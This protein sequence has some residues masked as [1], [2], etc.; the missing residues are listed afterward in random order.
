MSWIFAIGLAVICFAVIALVFRVPHKGWTIVLAALALGLAGYGLQASPSLRG[1]PKPGVEREKAAGFQIV[2]LRRA[3]VGTDRRS[4]SPLSV[5][6]DALIRQGEFADAANL[7]R[8]VV[9]ANPADGDAW[10]ALGNALAF[11][12]DGVPTP[13]ALLA[14]DRAAAEL[15][16]SAGPP[17]FVGLGLIREG[18]LIEA[19]KL[20]T[21]S[22]AAL[23][24]DAPGRDILADRLAALQALMRRIAEGADESAR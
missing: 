15:P 10:L 16:D 6:A 5:T 20:W 19:H 24:P 7:L 11:H 22:L 13:A 17:L 1:A 2:E 9:H 14:Y 4:R 23:P 8:G 18:R 3:L 12:A 21:R